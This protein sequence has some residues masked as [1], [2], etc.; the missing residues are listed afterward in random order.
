MDSE[1]LNSKEQKI[2]EQIFNNTRAIDNLFKK[3]TQLEIDGKLGS[4]EY[5]KYLEYIK[6]ANESEYELYKKITEKEIEDLG[7]Y[8]I[9]DRIPEN[10]LNNLNSINENKNDGNIERRI[11]DFLQ[12][13]MKTNKNLLLNH[14]SIELAE[15]IAKIIAEKIIENKNDNKINISDIENEVINRIELRLEF[16]RDYF[17]T[18]LLMLNFY[19]NSTFFEKYKNDLIACKY[20][21][22]LINPRTGEDLLKT[23]FEIQNENYLFS[24]LCAELKGYDKNKYN[25]LKDDYYKDIII[26]QI[27]ITLSECKNELNRILHKC[28]LKALFSLTSDNL[29]ETINSGF[30]NIID[31]KEYNNY[32]KNNVKNEE[33]IEQAFRATK[34]N[35]HKIK[36]LTINN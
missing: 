8:I 1:T 31:S 19:I 12:Y 26:S 10:F 16:E 11:L 24:S 17:N 9:T 25:E 30:H 14:K 27:I 20:R 2:F 22:L 13:E 21:T 28:S 3:L 5:K 35:K 6:I 36:L 34:E 7:K 33:A 15:V 18:F 29:V 23:N 4:T 32:Y